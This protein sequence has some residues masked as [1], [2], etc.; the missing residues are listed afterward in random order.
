VSGN[1]KRSGI[2][3]GFKQRE[4]ETGIV[5][6]DQRSAQSLVSDFNSSSLLIV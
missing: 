2:R 5:V 6:V 4:M 3:E 1:V